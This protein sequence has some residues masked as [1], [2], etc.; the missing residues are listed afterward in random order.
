MRLLAH[1]PSASTRHDFCIRVALAYAGGAHVALNPTS[2]GRKASNHWAVP[3]G[4][5]YS[6]PRHLE[7]KGLRD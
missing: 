3:N 1:E 5:R 6:H 4:A 2:L 7:C